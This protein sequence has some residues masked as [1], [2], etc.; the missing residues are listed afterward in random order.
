MAALV[1]VLF[2]LSGLVALV[3]Q[4]AWVRALG[5]LVGNSLWASVVVVAAYMGGMALGSAVVARLAGRI[6]AHLRLY[7]VAEALAALAALAT[8]PALAL[9]AGAAAHLGAEPLSGWGLP[10]AGRFLLAWAFLAVPTVAMGTTLPLLVERVGGEPRLAR[11]VSLLYAANT[12]GAVAGVVLAG[13]VALPLLGERGT[14]ATAAT[15]GLLVAVV[16]WA[17]ERVVPSPL[18][19]VPAATAAAPGRW[20]LFPALFGFVA[21]GA[22]LVWTRVLLLHLGSRVYAF[23]LIL[24]VYLAGLAIGSA[25]AR[26][27]RSDPRRALVFCQAA[28]ALAFAAQVPALAALGD[29]I[30]WLGATL[31]PAG[32]GALQWSLA[33]AVAAVLLPPTV[34]FGAT[35]PLSVAAY[36]G[37][38]SD[39]ARTGAVGA[40]NTLGGIAG[41]I[42]GPLLLV[43]LIGTQATLLA[44]G[45]ASALLAAA[46]ARSRPGR[47]AAAVGAVAVVA[48]A[49]L[50]PRGA[51][52][53]G[54][55]VMAEGTV[56]TLR[57]SA[58]GTVVVHRYEDARGGWRSLELNGVNVAGTSPELR[59][60]QRLQGHLPLLLH[61]APQRVL[62]IGFGSGGT[63]WAVTRHP[64][65]EVVIAEISPE[66][67]A[68]S[69]SV[70]DDVNHGVLADPRVRV[71]LNDGRNALLAM[72]G[73]FDAILSDSIH[74]VYAGNSTLYTREYF[75]L[76]RRRLTPGGVVSMWLPMY[77]LSVDSYLGI[78]RAFA[79][80]FPGAAVWYS[81]LV[82]N[83]FTV[84]TGTADPGPL[85][86]RWQALGDPALAP[87]LAEAGAASAAE[88]AGTLLLGPR[89]VATLVADVPLHVDDLPEVEYRSGRLLD[90]EGSWHRNFALL[91]AARARAN[92]YAAFPGDWGVVAAA[93]DEVLVGHL[94]EL[95]ARIA[96]R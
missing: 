13:F 30:A 61:P 17:A 90:R 22:E 44:F 37:R 57:E 21:L 59:A 86:V 85:S 71:V 16:A 34:L 74:P 46:L 43:P 15:V 73:T 52:L 31:R 87:T 69:G 70:F 72:G 49:A 62:H 66:V 50:A 89:E 6:R 64:V 58:A 83:E 20:L 45:A 81:P 42:A 48:V 5:L 19:T 38:G 53:R 39:A 88:L 51:V 35:F 65:A 80:V 12:A 67:L 2:V 3:Y 79:E 28:L 95:A 7:A 4:V 92:P 76:C 36:P 33:A 60:V 40:A 94:R 63:A 1:T 91:Y 9:L 54:A 68:V 25:A 29:L 8:A 75:E 18:P 27:W 32:F 56:E 24:A 96:S 11:R 84:V 93:R 55:G 47:A 23:A 10:L 78:L 82:L 26:V 14:L 77:S 41:S